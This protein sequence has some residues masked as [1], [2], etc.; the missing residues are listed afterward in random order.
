MFKN[1]ED[2]R[3]RFRSPKIANMSEQRKFPSVDTLARAVDSSISEVYRV[4][5]AREAIAQARQSGQSVDENQLQR[6]TL[7]K[8]KLLAGPSLRSLINMSGVVLHTG[9][10]RA[11]MAESVAARMA[12]VAGGHAR[13]E[14]N[15]DDGQRGDR[16]D[17][18]RDLLKDLTGAEDALVVNNCASAVILALSALCS[19]REVVISRGEMV[20]IGGAFR[21]PDIIKQSGCMLVEV[22]CTNKTHLRDFEGATTEETASYLR[23]HQS[24]FAITGFESRPDYQA[25]SSLAKKS[26][27]MVLDDMGSGCLVDTTQYGLPKERTL[28][29]AVSHGAD[30]V[31]ASGDKLLGGPQAGILV[32]TKEA[33][34]Q[35]KKHPLARALRCDKVTVAGL[36]ATLRLYIEGRELE[37]PTWNYLAKESEDVK[38]DAETLQAAWNGEANVCEG[39]TE[40]GGGSLPGSGV[41]TWQCQLRSKSSDL[42]SLHTKLRTEFGIV[43][44]IQS[45][46]LNL[47]PRTASQE[48]I[49]TVAK[50]L[51]GLS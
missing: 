2:S 14:F 10:G 5:A 34:K 32:G 40:I 25:L 44:S 21:M 51:E 39:I 1:T 17:H 43:G 45:S 11:R 42:D 49:Q 20:E 41:K 31:M 13:L 24:N 36:E 18:L 47:D 27:V 22:G 35:C 38:T 4:R 23:C 12:E 26:G 8:A 50:I 3:A 15:L 16:Q 9:L 46:W 48:E 7:E 30:V 37:V 33:I 29:E 19:G 28:K 6:D